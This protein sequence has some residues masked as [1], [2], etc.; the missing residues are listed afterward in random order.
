ML[1]PLAGDGFSPT[2]AQDLG[3]LGLLGVA[4]GVFAAA[5]SEAI[6]PVEY[7]PLPYALAEQDPLDEAGGELEALLAPLDATVP[8]PFPRSWRRTGLQPQMRIRWPP[9]RSGWTQPL[10]VS[11]VP[12]L[13]LEA[14]VPLVSVA[15][16]QDFDADL[17]EADLEA[18]TLPTASERT[19]GQGPL[20][21]AA[22]LLADQQ[23]EEDAEAEPEVPSDNAALQS[24]FAQQEP[25]GFSGAGE[26][27]M[28]V[29]PLVLQEYLLQLEARKN[30]EEEDEEEEADDGDSDLP[31]VAGEAAALSGAAF[32]PLLFAGSGALSDAL[33]GVDHQIPDNLSDIEELLTVSATDI[34]LGTTL[35]ADTGSSTSTGGGGGG[36]GAQ[37]AAST[38][39]G[40]MGDSMEQVLLS[41]QLPAHV[42]TPT[43][44]GG[45]PGNLE[46]AEEADVENADLE[47]LAQ[48]IY[49]LLRQ[50]LEVERER[51]GHHYLG[52]MPW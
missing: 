17:L 39:S 13:G 33:G 10:G 38:Y 23:P 25:D 4:A 32:A 7:G 3:V 42:P 9:G 19:L 5:G 22:Q 31:T 50:R 30:A 20:L 24:D 41:G 8:E 45:S 2:V 1:R 29:E 21:F 46:E 40:Y 52:R 28:E 35:P 26:D 16:L 44:G 43:H 14:G 11:E 48:E 15:D 6:D 12:A 47:M 36:G 18:P 37:E 51:S 34:G 49:G 27:E